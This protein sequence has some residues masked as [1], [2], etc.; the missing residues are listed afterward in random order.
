[1]FGV[2]LKISSTICHALHVLVTILPYIIIFPLSLLWQDYFVAIENLIQ[3]CKIF[4]FQQKEIYF[5]YQ[6][7]SQ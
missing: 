4:C 7:K 3:M 1:M 2:P 6:I 5:L